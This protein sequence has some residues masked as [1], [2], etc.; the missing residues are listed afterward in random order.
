MYQISDRD[1]ELV[2]RALKLIGRQNL[3]RKDRESLRMA[4]RCVPKFERK[5]RAKEDMP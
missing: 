1:M 2:V 5:M 4:S 3:G